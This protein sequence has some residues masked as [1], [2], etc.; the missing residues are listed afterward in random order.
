MVQRPA[1]RTRCRTRLQELR[2]LPRRAAQADVAVVV[3]SQQYEIGR[4]SVQERRLKRLAGVRRN[5]AVREVC[6]V[7]VWNALELL[8]TPRLLSGCTD[9]DPCPATG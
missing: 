5:V 7:N 9:A 8:R 1:C 4:H 3:R 6:G 2:D